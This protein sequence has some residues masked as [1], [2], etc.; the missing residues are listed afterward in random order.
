[1]GLGLLSCESVE[2]IG[3]IRRDTETPGPHTDRSDTFYPTSAEEET[4]HPTEAVETD[5]VSG[6]GGT[7][8][9]ADVNTD[10]DSDSASEKNIVDTGSQK[11]TDPS[12]DTTSPGTGSPGTE[13]D[14]ADMFT[15]DSVT[16]LGGSDTTDSGSDADIP[17][18]PVETDTPEDSEIPTEPGCDL[19]TMYVEGAALYDTCGERFIPIGVNEMVVW[20]DDRT[21]S[22]IFP[23][24]SLTGAN[25]VRFS[26]STGNPAYSGV[27]PAVSELESAIDNCNAH[28]M[29]AIVDMHDRGELPSDIPETVDWWIQPEVV[30]VI[31]RHEKHLMINILSGAGPETVSPSLYVSLFRD[32][33]TLMREAGIR[34]PLIIETSGPGG[35]VATL[36]E[37]STP[38]LDADPLHNLLFGLHMWWPSP[39]GA[40]SRII[41]AIQGSAAL[42][43][44]LLISE[45][46]PMGQG[47]VQSIDYE[48]VM[49]EAW[50]N[51]YGFLAWSWGAVAN[52]DC[53]YLGMT[54]DGTYG[55]WRDTPENGRWGEQVA[56]LSQYSIKKLAVRSSA[57][58]R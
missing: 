58:S 11:E 31:Q 45:F 6:G 12:S 30:S 8:T 2:T 42:E 38:L 22:W 24:I 15:S 53:E 56:E 5:S 25:T 57:F 41:D 34:V 26:W 40:T 37:I 4:S 55:H 36:Q 27:S 18:S 21:G 19:P 39:D 16:D 17:T 49:E 51:G 43:V 9:G 32:G 29:V 33:I 23:Q 47:C 20:A 1:M 7:D 14:S 13:D 3:Y 44:P 54:T 35:D 46:A 28:E 52:N 10:S 48:T 50:L